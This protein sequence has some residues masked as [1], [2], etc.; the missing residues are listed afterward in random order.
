MERRFGIKDKNEK[1]RVKVRVSQTLPVRS[2]LFACF[3]CF[4]SILFMFSFSSV[5][6][7]ESFVCLSKASIK[8]E[9]LNNIIIIEDPALEK[10]FDCLALSFSLG[11]LSFCLIS[12]DDV[13]IIVDFGL[14][15]K[16]AL[17]IA[18]LDKAWEDRERERER[19]CN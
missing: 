7:S 10:S 11:K 9:I 13:R 6:L 18:T 17:L 5:D 14:Q 12:R 19:G 4:M 2:S 16:H 15:S 1:G 8:Y 3:Q